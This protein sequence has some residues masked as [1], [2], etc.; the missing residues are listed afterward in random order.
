MNSYCHHCKL[1]TEGHPKAEDCIA[2]LRFE[3]E[4]DNVR[5]GVLDPAQYASLR[6]AF[7][8]PHARLYF[9]IAYHLGM[10]SGEILR[11]RWD[12]VDLKA[13]RITLEGKQVKNKIARVAPI[14]GDM[15]AHLEM[16]KL[17]ASAKCNRVI[18]LDGSP[19]NSIRRAWSTAC[20][21]AG[22]SLIPH[23]MRRTAVTNMIEAGVPEDH[24]MAV[25]GHR[26]RSMLARYSITGARTADRVRERM[27]AWAAQQPKIEKGVIQ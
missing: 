19:V 9:V 24:A 8:A 18:Q 13:G 1:E 27:E 17:T 7:Q 10:R 21:L 15:A 25:S 11:L 14:Y 26:T 3:W 2:A 20:R 22:L 5:Q 6:N 4:V 12:Q 23:D 16:A